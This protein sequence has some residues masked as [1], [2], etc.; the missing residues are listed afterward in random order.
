M[1]LVF[2]GIVFKI[3]LFIVAV[4]SLIGHLVF[5]YERAY[6]YLKRDAPEDEGDEDFYIYSDRDFEKK[7]ASFLL[8]VFLFALSFLVYL[9][10]I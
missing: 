4:A 10:M 2:I 5:K 9:F 1:I 6:E 3:L 7:V 8:Q